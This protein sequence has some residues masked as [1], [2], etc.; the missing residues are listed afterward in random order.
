SWVD[1]QEVDLVAEKHADGPAERPE[2]DSVRRQPGELDK[3]AVANG[4]DAD[5][6]ITDAAADNRPAEQ[7]IEPP[8][9][10]AGVP[11]AENAEQHPPQQPAQGAENRIVIDANEKRHKLVGP[12]K[13]IGLFYS[14]RLVAGLQR[15]GGDGNSRLPIWSRATLA[16]R[17]FLG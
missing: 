11:V 2:H 4:L 6:K 15:H 5:D 3:G 1:E 16:R 12:R 10:F 8:R 9:V 13:K 17:C 7:R 14:Y